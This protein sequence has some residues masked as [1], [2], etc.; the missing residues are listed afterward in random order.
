MKRTMDPEG[1][2]CNSC[3]SWPLYTHWA[4]QRAWF[5]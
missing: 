3:N 5:G 4:D 1:T 2:A